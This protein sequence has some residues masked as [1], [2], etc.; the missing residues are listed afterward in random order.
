[1]SNHGRP[2]RPVRPLRDLTDEE[3]QD[4]RRRVMHEGSKVHALAMRF[5]LSEWDAASLM[6]AVI[7]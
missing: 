5:K 1:M 2:P 3:R 4:F 6:Q 7:R